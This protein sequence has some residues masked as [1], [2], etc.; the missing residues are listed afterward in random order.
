[1]LEAPARGRVSRAGSIARACLDPSSRPHACGFEGGGPRTA[2]RKEPIVSGAATLTVLADG[3]ATLTVEIAWRLARAHWRRGLAT[4]A[5]RAAV[6]LGFRIPWLVELV[7]F[8]VP[9][10]LASRR[11]M[12]KLGMQHDPREDFDHPA[13]AEGHPLRKHV[14]Y[15]LSRERWMASR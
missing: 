3:A 11:V 10:N 15:R 13:L 14:L 6:E 1:M 5:A 2:S 12:E 9:M 4:E 8:T 7:S